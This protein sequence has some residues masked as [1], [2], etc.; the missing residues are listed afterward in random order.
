MRHK[1][2]A[3]TPEYFVYFKVFAADLWGKRTAKAR[4]RNCAVL[5]LILPH[6]TGKGQCRFLQWGIS[7]MVYRGRGRRGEDVCPIFITCS[8]ASAGSG[9]GRYAAKPP[10]CKGRCRPHRAAE[11]LFPS[12]RYSRAASDYELLNS[13]AVRSETVCVAAIPHPR[14][15][16]LRILC[17]RLEGGKRSRSAAPPLPSEPADAGL[18]RGPES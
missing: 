6:F 5:P 9:D 10:L 11:G 1:F 12:G 2:V 4:R 16:K 8:G 15:H 17:F 13:R 18:R 7:I 3:K 14:R